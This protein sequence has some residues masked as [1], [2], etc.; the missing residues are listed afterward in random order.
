MPMPSAHLE[1]SH[2]NYFNAFTKQFNFKIKTFKILPKNME[3]LKLPFL[4][5]TEFWIKF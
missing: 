1:I 3:S 2:E 4:K 5:N